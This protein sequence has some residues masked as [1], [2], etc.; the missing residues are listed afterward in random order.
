MFAKAC[1]DRLKIISALHVENRIKILKI[2]GSRSV[3]SSQNTGT[4]KKKK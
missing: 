2:A 1:I 4:S 3:A